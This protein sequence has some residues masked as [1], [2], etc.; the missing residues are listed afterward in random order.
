MGRSDTS[1][2]KKTGHFNL[3]TTQFWLTLTS[4]EALSCTE[5][6]WF[7]KGGNI[8]DSFR[9]AYLTEINL[10]CDKYNS[11]LRY[12]F[13]FSCFAVPVSDHLRRKRKEN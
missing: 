12:A 4:S 1:V 7:W 6:E 5:E 8:Y 10:P 3:L 2:A 13:S 11:D 9:A